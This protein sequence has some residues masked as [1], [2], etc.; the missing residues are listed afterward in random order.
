MKSG[1]FYDERVEIMEILSLALPEEKLKDASEQIDD[2]DM[3][4]GACFSGA[5]DRR[6]YMLYKIPN[7]ILLYQADDWETYITYLSWF[8]HREL[9][10]E[11]DNRIIGFE[12]LYKAYKNMIKTVT[13]KDL[14]TNR[15]N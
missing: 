4:I 13:E 12:T 3:M 11:E 2:D 5:L 10:H 15:A 9:Q 14:N 6:Y 8:M 1:R 7:T